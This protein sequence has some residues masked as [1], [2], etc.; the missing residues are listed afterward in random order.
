MPN[1]LS[2]DGEVRFIPQSLV[3][4]MR[5]AGW[6]FTTQKP[7]GSIASIIAD[8]ANVS[9]RATTIA[10][11]DPRRAGQRAGPGGLAGG[12]AGHDIF[13]NNTVI[14]ESQDG[15]LKIT[16]ANFSEV[17]RSAV[18]D[19]YA[20]IRNLGFSGGLTR[21]FIG[22]AEHIQWMRDMNAWYEG[23]I[24]ADQAAAVG[25]EFRFGSDSEGL[26]SGFG[27]I[28]P[29]Y[30]RPDEL[31]VTEFLKSYVVATTGTIDDP[32]TAQ[33]VERYLNAH[34]QNFDNPGQDIDALLAAQTVVRDSAV[35]KDIHELRPEGQDEMT[36]VT[37]QQGLLRQLGVSSTDSEKLGIKL[38]R[39]GASRAANKAAG[40]RTIFSSSGRIAE[41]QRKRLKDSAS[42][43]MGLL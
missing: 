4:T 32:L 8:R 18:A 11:D 30:V 42:A 43:V 38:A 5:A 10:A 6:S 33:A 31:Q 19:G 24:T 23:Y 14:W 16:G 1:M 3:P 22:S 9:G 29:V 7:A 15:A 28:G 20:G 41:D 12:D 40:E 36:W 26:G 2:K 27:R 37:S 25:Q 34:R 35:Y 17:M 13:F 39:V 21:K